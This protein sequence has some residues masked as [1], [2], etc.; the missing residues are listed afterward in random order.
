[1]SCPGCSNSNQPV[2]SSQGFSPGIS[3]DEQTQPRDTQTHILQCDGYSDIRSSIELD[4]MNDELLAD[5]FIKV[6]QR[7]IENGED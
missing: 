2:P 7:R 6:V 5:Y 3:S 1:M 4:P